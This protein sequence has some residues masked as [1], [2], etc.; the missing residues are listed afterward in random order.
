MALS[1]AYGS[2]LILSRRWKFGLGSSRS[3]NPRNQKP[4]GASCDSLCSRRA[5]PV[6][7]PSRRTANESWMAKA[8]SR[9]QERLRVA[10]LSATAGSREGATLILRK[11]AERCLRRNA[12]QRFSFA[13][14][15][16]QIVES[17]PQFARQ[18]MKRSL[19]IRSESQLVAQ[20]A[21]ELVAA[22][23]TILSKHPHIRIEQ[24]GKRLV[25]WA[26]EGSAGGC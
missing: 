21:S 17:R 20:V 19:R 9:R 6:R 14:L 4:F 12:G 10:N 5:G 1:W 23:A 7:R 22:K 11:A 26:E 18:K 2:I 16:R 24:D 13:Q 25:L 15:A 8:A 3:R